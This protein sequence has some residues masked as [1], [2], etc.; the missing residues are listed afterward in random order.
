MALPDRHPDAKRDRWVYGA[1]VALALSILEH[2]QG[3]A[4]SRIERA[5]MA[6]KGAPVDEIRAAGEGH[7]RLGELV[8]Q[9]VE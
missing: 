8:E 3:D 7:A 6:L 1:R 5:V 4:E 2:T 9:A